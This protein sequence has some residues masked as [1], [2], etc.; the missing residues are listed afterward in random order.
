MKKDIIVKISSIL[1]CQKRPEKIRIR[2]ENYLF[3]NWKQQKTHFAQPKTSQKSNNWE[4][5]FRN[6]AQ[7]MSPMKLKG[8]P[9]QKFW[10]SLTKP[11][12]AESFLAS[13]KVE[14]NG[15]ALE[16]FCISW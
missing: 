2:V 4:K 8:D 5:K 9:L 1:Q 16:W 11:K 13:K 3:P 6:L 12:K 7:K 10:K 15:S 14:R